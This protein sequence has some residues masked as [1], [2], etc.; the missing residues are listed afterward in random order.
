[1]TD[2]TLSLV[3]VSE[4]IMMDTTVSLLHV[5]EQTMTNT[6]T[7]SLVGTCE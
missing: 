2:I 3:H 6:S 7:L 4:R 5:S 1:M